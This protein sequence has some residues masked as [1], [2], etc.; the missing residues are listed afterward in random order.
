[1]PNIISASRRTDIPQF[2]GD[3]FEARR[4]A[5]YCESRNV[6]GR[7]YRISLDRE[8]VLG[9]LFWTK[10]SAPFERRLRSLLA[11]GV[12]AAVQ[13]TV[14]GYGPAV[15]A[16][17][18]ALSVTVPA[19][20]RASSLL[21][22]PAAIQWRYDP[23]VLSKSFDSDWHRENF[24]RIASRL[25]G[26]TRVCNVSFVEPYAKVVRR[27]GPEIGYRTV[28]RERHGKVSDRHP[29]LRAA[30]S[31]GARLVEEL[32]AVAKEHGIELRGC[33]NPEYRLPPAQC[34]GAEL[35][36]DYG[37]S[38]QLEAL[39]AAPSRMFC[40]CLRVLDIGMDDSCPGGCRYCYVTSAAETAEG[41]YRRR[42]VDAVRLR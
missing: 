31:E 26:A 3:W 41:N 18:P 38:A 29:A 21:P 7:S 13:F 30:G 34:C 11:E 37:I 33:C 15:E 9:Y 40:R 4:K 8:D 32:S 22:G 17:I 28:I 14:T 25:E 19:F 42:N 20:R 16:N 10:N 36:R 39:P 12:P 35:F 24:R 5:G 23:I 2:Y 1:M 27:M 6:F